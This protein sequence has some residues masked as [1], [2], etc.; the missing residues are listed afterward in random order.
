MRHQPRDVAA[1]LLRRARRRRQVVT[2]DGPDHHHRRDARRV[3][4]LRRAREFFAPLCLTRA[5]VEGSNGGN[6]LIARLKPGVTIAQA[7]TEL[8]ALTERLATSDPRRHKGLAVRV[9]SLTRAGA[10]TLDAI[11]QPT[12]DYASSLT[13]LQ[14]AVALVLLIACANVAGLLLARGA[15]RRAE[16]A[17]RMTLGAGKWRVVRQVPDGVPALGAARRRHRHRAGVGGIE[18][19]VAGGASGLPASGRCRSIIRVLAFTAPSSS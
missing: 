15:T 3:R 7:Q 11:G 19:F 10:R 1:P 14:G 8:E 2:L 12:S 17:L 16:L 18:G 4:F 6:S 13:I 5:Q 9:E